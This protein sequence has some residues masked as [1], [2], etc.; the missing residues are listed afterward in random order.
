ML[1]NAE[2]SW[3]NTVIDIYN[4]SDITCGK[5]KTHNTLVSWSWFHLSWHS[6]WRPIWKNET[7]VKQGSVVADTYGLYMKNFTN[8]SFPE[9]NINKSILSH[10]ENCR[11][12]GIEYANE[13]SL[14]QKNI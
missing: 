14:S 10:L 8:V 7:S 1:K 11:L 3:E 5:Q 6:N 12:P 2:I 13:L 4:K 9:T